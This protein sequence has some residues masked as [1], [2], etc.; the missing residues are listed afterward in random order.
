VIAGII[1]FDYGASTIRFGYTIDPAEARQI[2]ALLKEGLDNT[3]RTGRLRRAVR[4][5]TL[6]GVI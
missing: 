2:V 4:A 1:A 6:L 5:Q 3:W